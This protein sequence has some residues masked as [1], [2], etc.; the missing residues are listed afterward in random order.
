LKEYL[1][2]NFPVDLGNRTIESNL[3]DIFHS[4][5]DFLSFADEHKDKKGNS[6]IGKWESYYYRT[7]S[8]INLR[9]KVAAYQ[10]AGKQVLF[11]SISPALFSYGKW[12]NEQS[13]L[14]LDWTRT[15]YPYVRRE[16]I[17]RDVAFS[18]HKNILNSGSRILCWS[19]SLIENLQEIYGVKS[20]SL[21]KAPAPFLFEKMDNPPRPTPE[22]PRVLFVGGDFYRKGGDVILDAV[23]KGLT[24]HCS[25]SM[26]TNDSQANVEGVNFLPGIKYGSAEHKNIFHDHDILLLPTRMDSLPQVIGEAA[27]AGL[28]VITTKFALASKDVIQHG[29]SGFIAESSE[30]CIMYLYELL[31]NRDLIDSFKQQGYDLMKS[32]YSAK[33]LRPKYLNMLS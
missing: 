14:I 9:K 3:R 24:N 4:D 18:L 22:K 7:K 19:D 25:L 17:R 10:R 31:K 29:N 32:N 28:A 6:K 5:M 27:S 33:T 30:E 13:A 12:N 11:N 1:M 21:I 20:S 8:A 15:L 26:M 16:K 2:V 23:K